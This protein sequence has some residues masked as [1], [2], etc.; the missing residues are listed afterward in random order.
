MSPIT[1]EHV[2]RESLHSLP[3][4]LSPLVGDM[5]FTITITPELPYSSLQNEN[6][7]CFWDESEISEMGKLSQALLKSY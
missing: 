2:T 5:V 1:L 6:E 3:E 7:I 4:K